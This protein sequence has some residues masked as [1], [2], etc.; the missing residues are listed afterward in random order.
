MLQGLYFGLGHGLGGL[1]GGIIYQ[2]KGGQMVFIAAGEAGIQTLCVVPNSAASAPLGLNLL[3]ESA[4]CEQTAW[5]RGACCC[6]STGLQSSKLLFPSTPLSIT[7]GGLHVKL[8]CSLL[9]QC[10][11]CCQDACCLPSCSRS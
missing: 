1:C 6:A 10:W 3:L 7:C 11:C 9:M 5:C 8:T 2:K 4:S